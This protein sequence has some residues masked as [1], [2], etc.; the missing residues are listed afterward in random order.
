MWMYSVKP[1]P[2]QSYLPKTYV[3]NDG[4]EQVN[5][6]PNSIQSNRQCQSEAEL[7][8]GFTDVEIKPGQDRYRG[9]HLVRSSNVRITGDYL[10]PYLNTSGGVAR[11]G[12]MHFGGNKSIIWDEW[13]YDD[14]VTRTYGMSLYAAAVFVCPPGMESISTTNPDDASALCQRTNVGRYIRVQR[15]QYLSCP[16]N[17]NPCHPSSTDKTR[18]ETDFIFAGRPFTR[19]YHSLRESRPAGYS[20]GNGWLNSYSAQLYDAY[21]G[22]T[23]VTHDGSWAPY[24]PV[25]TGHWLVPSLNNA[26]LDQQ[27]DGS[28]QLIESSGEISTFVNG[29]LTAMRMPS[30]PDNDVSFE[31]E[32]DGKLSR[33]LDRAGRALLFGYDRWSRLST[34]TLPDGVVF[35][36][37]YDSSDNLISVSSS[38]GG[39]KQYHYGEVGL[40]A[41]RDPGLLTGITYEDGRRYAS[42]GYDTHGRVL[43]S[44]LL[45]NNGQSVDATRIYYSADNAAQV[46]T[47]SGAERHYTYTSDGY[48]NPLSI[49]DANGTVSYTYDGYGQLVSRSDFNGVQTHYGYTNGQLTQMVAAFDT[50]VQRKEETEWDALARKPFERRAYDAGNILIEKT[51]WTYNPRGQILTTARTDPATGVSRTT[52]NTWCEQSDIDNGTCPRIGL[53]LSIDGPRTDTADITTYTYYPSDDP[54]C[55]TEPTTCPHRKGDLWKVTNALGQVT[56]TLAY[57]G[58]GRPLSVR[59]ANGVITDFRYDARGHLTLRKVRGGSEAESRITRIAY[60]PTGLVKRVTQPDGSYTVYHY[61]A[62][63]RLIGIDDNAGNRIRYT[64]DNAGN[65]IKEDT[66][67][68][69]GTLT[70]R[71]SRVHDELGRLQSQADAYGHATGYAYDANGNATSTTDALGRQT[72]NVYDPLNRL[73]ATLQDVGGIEAQ[74]QFTY[75]AQDNLTRV[76]DPKGLHTDYTYNGLGDLLQLSSPDTGITQYTYDSA[77]NRSSQTDARGKTQTYTYDALNRLTQITGPSRKYLYDSGNTSVCPAGERFNKGRLSGFNDPSGT[78][79]YCYNRFGD[80]TQKVQT[81]NGLVFATRYSYDSAG[82]LTATTYPDGAVLDAVYDGNGQV[83]ELGVTPNGGSRQIVLSGVTYAPFGPATGW[84]Y[85]NGRILLRSLNR[86]Y[87]PESIHDDA[88]DGLSLRYG[89]DEVGN[90]TLLRQADQNKK[91]AQYGYDGLNR[92]TQVMDG[93]TGTPIETY[94]YDATGNRTELTSAGI[95]TAYAYGPDSH[96]LDKVGNIARLYDAAGNTTKIGGNARQFVYDNSGRMTQ[97]KSGGV[98]TRQYEYNA[99]GEQTRGHLDADSAYFSY[100]E[101][102]HLLGEYGGDGNPKQQLLWFGDLPVGVLQGAGPSQALHYIE[103][104]HLGTPRAIIDGTRNVAI[105]EWKLTG[106]AFGATPPNQDPDQ[107]GNAFT[108]NLR[109]PGQRY[110]EVTGLNYNYFRDYDPVT[111]RYIESDPI[112]IDAGPATYGYALLNPTGGIDP[113]GL[114]TL[115]YYRA[116]NVL[117]VM[118]GKGAPY[119]IHAS[120][121]RSDCNQCTERDRNKGP[122]PRGDYR[123]YAR[124]LSDPNFVGDAMRNLR[125]DWGDWRVR[126]WPDDAAATHGRDGFFLHGGWQPGSAGCIDVGGGIFGD[127]ITDRLA[128]DIKADPDG[129]IH[130]RVR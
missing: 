113:S 97:V 117:W 70:R 122:I 71:L 84:Q 29:R 38:Q 19:Y 96:R 20:M 101:A 98:I 120:S 4:R 80:L 123:A 121:G 30:V 27:G 22:R 127:D 111:G 59:D 15:R 73:V 63:Q 32:G 78:T 40:S 49:T 128:N 17:D 18:A 55:A 53:L 61:D 52:A 105:W 103:P 37:G 74:T 94:A 81:T 60:W 82:R 86:N 57:D 100:D 24:V 119:K 64:L 11:E 67:D 79:R 92:L 28:W 91:L 58:A 31:Y 10:T 72:A 9:W 102:G 14:K 45:D 3:V 26:S 62:A 39:V 23:M 34:I 1:Q 12:L 54:A 104:D 116:A 99:K 108:F 87:Q 112:G 6:C 25:S 76:T 124:E 7:I 46:T 13:D 47:A 107:D 109:F 48:H 42:F 41:N 2:P 130:V 65:R 51:N 129:V 110:D 21:M 68:P 115:L 118:P 90:L 89:F 69:S 75:D 125:G 50:D 33:V 8:A 88:A 43:L 95:T 16:V 35:T 56:E 77:G 36:Y 44:T 66:R 126:L 93:P 114:L 83:A 5:Y 85:G 106:E